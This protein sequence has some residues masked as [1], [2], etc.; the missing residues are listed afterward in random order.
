MV[1]TASIILSKVL[2]LLPCA[3]ERPRSLSPDAQRDWHK[4]LMRA[5]GWRVR[6]GSHTR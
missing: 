4:I 6:H 3:C 5:R 1:S 2:L